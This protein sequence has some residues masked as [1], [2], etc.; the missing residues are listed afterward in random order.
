MFAILVQVDY[1]I[2]KY[3]QNNDISIAIF[4]SVVKHKVGGINTPFLHAYNVVEFPLLW[5]EIKDMVA[6]INISVISV[7]FL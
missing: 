5:S 2:K 6:F 7:V 4:Y 1:T 3:N